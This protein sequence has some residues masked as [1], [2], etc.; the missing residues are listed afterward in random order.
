LENIIFKETTT[1]GIRRVKMERTILERSKESVTLSIGQLSVKKCI[2]P[3][4]TIRK[5]PEYENVASLAQKNNMS[6]QEV[7][8]TYNKELV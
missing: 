7:I 6:I 3:D 2:L 8:S 5:Y 4:G 1:I